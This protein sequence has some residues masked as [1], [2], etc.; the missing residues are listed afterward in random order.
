M[1]YM[2]LKRLA[3]D[4]PWG[5]QERGPG[6]AYYDIVVVGPEAVPVI[7]QVH[8]RTGE[9][10]VHWS[11]TYDGLLNIAR[12]VGH[13][14]EQSREAI[15]KRDPDGNWHEVIVHISDEIA[16]EILAKLKAAEEVSE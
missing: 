8:I 4:R 12:S 14:I 9:I 13:A 6:E 2:E 5:I 7:E 10:L 15:K 3:A 16:D 1:K 11:R